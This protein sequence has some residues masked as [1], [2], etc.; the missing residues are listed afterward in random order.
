MSDE[1]AA[2]TAAEWA[3]L[4]AVADH[5]IPAADEMPS[6]AEVVDAARLQFVLRSRPDLGTR[7][8]L[9][10]ARTWGRTWSRA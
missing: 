4:A 8:G 10:C 9:R 7:C 2:L 5:L 6:A 1:A 3:T